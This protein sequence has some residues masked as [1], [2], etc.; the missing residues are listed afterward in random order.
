MTQKTENTQQRCNN[1]KRRTTMR[2]TNNHPTIMRACACVDLVNLC[3]TNCLPF[4]AVFS[5]SPVKNA[6][7]QLEAAHAL[8]T[9]LLLAR[10]VCCC[11]CCFVVV[12]VVVVLL[13]AGACV[14]AVRVASTSCVESEGRPY[15]LC[16]R[17][18]CGATNGDA[19]GLQAGERLILVPAGRVA[20]TNKAF[21]GV[22]KKCLL[23]PVWLLFCFVCFYAD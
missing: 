5:N 14:V 9:L 23:P 3:R 17:L 12:V 6:S 20:P 4:T 16:C 21:K 22:S 10:R 8:P 11:C 7:C 1:N 19:W 13:L 15:D 18:L 2:P